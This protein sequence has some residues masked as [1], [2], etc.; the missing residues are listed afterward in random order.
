LKEE[1][2]VAPA[3]LRLLVNIKREKKG[4]GAQKRREHE[5]GNV[6]KKARWSRYKNKKKKNNQGEAGHSPFMRG[7]GGVC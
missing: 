5:S 2:E 7:D 4:P 1:R 3:H 6:E